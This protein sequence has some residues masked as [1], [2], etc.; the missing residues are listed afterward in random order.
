MEIDHSKN[1]IQRSE[2][3]EKHKTIRKQLR[4]K[5]KREGQN[6]IIKDLEEIEIIKL[7]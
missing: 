4:T 3:Q 2:L 7:D 6:D 1:D 5:L